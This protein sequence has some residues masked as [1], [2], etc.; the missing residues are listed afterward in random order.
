MKKENVIK[1]I[2]I[3]SIVILLSI[4]SFVGIYVKKANK[5]ENVMPD[6]KLGMDLGERRVVTL[7]VQ[8]GTSTITYDE[9]GNEVSNVSEDES[10]YTQKEVEINSEE[11]LNAENY[12][13]AKNTIEKRLK[14][15][16]IDDYTI[17]YSEETGDIIVEL[18]ENDMTDNA[19]DIL[20]ATGKIEMVSEETEEVLLSNN[21]FKKAKVSYY[22]GDSSTTVYLT[23]E[24]NKEGKQKLQEISNTYVDTVEQVITTDEE[25]GEETTSEETISKKVILRLDWPNSQTGDIKYS[26]VITQS[27]ESEMS[28]GILQLPIGTATTNEMLQSYYE[29]AFQISSILNSGLVPV[30][31]EIDGNEILGSEV[32]NIQILIPI[33]MVCVIFAVVSLVIIFK[34]KTLGLL[35]TISNISMVACL[36]IFIRLTKVTILTTAIPAIT[37]IIFA[38]TIIIIKLIQSMKDT[39]NSKKSIWKAIL[40]MIDLLIVIL[41]VAVTFIFMFNES[42]VAAG[43]IMFWGIISIIMTNLLFT[44][45]LLLAVSKN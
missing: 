4:I 19:V 13:K 30:Q 7:K 1:T 27:F 5:Y 23:I 2:L 44:K 28:G 33:I 3:I 8:S 18:P 12:K 29:I 45:P 34:Y 16:D 40:E 22:N 43:M 36:L 25:T 39:D 9:N 26:D 15:L 11:L 37:S 35:G 14:K 20:T 41:V 38:N 17:K 42:I 24:L 10:S 21:D 31:Y 32:T 6:Y